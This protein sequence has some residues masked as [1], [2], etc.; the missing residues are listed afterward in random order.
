MKVS[1]KDLSVEPLSKKNEFHDLT[2]FRSRFDSGL[3]PAQ[4]IYES[5]SVDMEIKNNG[6]ELD[7]YADGSTHL[8]DLI[9]TKTGLI[10]CKGKTAR[11][12]GEKVSWDEFI[13]WMEEIE[14]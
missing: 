2:P 1:I 10:W 12:N 3:S 7:V 9:V 4:G 6:V 8:G 11:A 14:P 5:G 13:D